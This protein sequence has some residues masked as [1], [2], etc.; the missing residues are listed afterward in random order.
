MYKGAS[1]QKV[2]R[3]KIA[4][5]FSKSTTVDVRSKIKEALVY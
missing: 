3:S 1:C 4:L 5:F 2:N